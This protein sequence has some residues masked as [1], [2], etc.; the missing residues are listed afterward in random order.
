MHSSKKGSTFE[1]SSGIFFFK[2]EKFSGCLSELGQS[3]MYSPDLLLVLETILSNKLQLMIDSFLLKRSSRCLECGRVYNKSRYYSSCS[4]F[5]SIINNGL[6]ILN[7]NYSKHPEYYLFLGPIF[8]VI[9][10]SEK[11]CS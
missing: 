4:F 5:P 1:K 3:K 10:F 9:L 6:F 11:L 8:G 2:S 7:I